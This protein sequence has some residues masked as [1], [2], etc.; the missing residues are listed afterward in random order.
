MTTE[1]AERPA[2]EIQMNPANPIG[3]ML[4]AITERGITT[5]SAAALEK[6]TD[7]Y[8]RVE[9][10]NA[11]K[12]FAKAKAE[13]QARLPHVVATKPVP[14]K[15]GSVRYTFAPYQ[16]IMRQVEP[17]LSQH[18]FSISFSQEVDDRRIVAICTLTHVGGHSESNRFAVRAGQGPP[19]CTETQADG[20]ASTYAKRFALCNCLNITVDMPDDDARLLGD[21]IT[22]EQAR[23]LEQRLSALGGSVEGFLKLAEA[24]SFVEIRASKYGMLVRAL[25]VKEKARRSQPPSDPSAPSEHE[26]FWIAAREA[27]QA[28]ELPEDRLKSGVKKW[29][30]KVG[31]VGKEHEAP[32]EEIAK[33][34]K[35][36]SERRGAFA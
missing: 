15:D 13:L 30:L 22:K 24:P 26:K 28:A 18:G 29:A 25:D 10:E 16:S 23:E 32:S 3:A 21:T 34:L 20:S 33:L 31:V 4:A 9:A 8:L 17:L 6:M 7:L 2:A 35:E 12:A 11:R 1:L 14:N 19:G 27:A 5:E 36:I